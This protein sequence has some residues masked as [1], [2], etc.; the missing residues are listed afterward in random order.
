MCGQEEEEMGLEGKVGIGLEEGEGG[1]LE[2]YI[3]WE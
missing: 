1:G 2:E 3:V